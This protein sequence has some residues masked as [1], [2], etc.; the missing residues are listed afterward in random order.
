[1]STNANRLPVELWYYIFRIAVHVPLLFCIE[2]EYFPQERLWEGWESIE[3]IAMETKRAIVQVCRSWREVGVQFLYE[4]IQLREE[5]SERIMDLV[6]VLQ[7]SASAS[8]QGY[9]GWIKRID[10]HST[11]VSSEDVERLASLLECCHN[12]QILSISAHEGS[13]A[14]IQTRLNPIIQSR[15]V[16]SL[17]RLDYFVDNIFKDG[18]LPNVR[19]TSLGIDPLQLSS[20]TPLHPSLAEVTTLTINPSSTGVIRHF[21][22]QWHLPRLRTLAIMHLIDPEIP[23][24]QPF[25]ERH[26]STL[27]H[28]SLQVATSAS[29]RN[30]GRL[31]G[32]LSCLQS[33]TLNDK[34]IPG[35]T[36]TA[37][38][39][40]RNAN[41]TVEY[42]GII[43]FSTSH[44]LDRD[45]ITKGLGDILQH[46]VFPKLKVVRLL[47][48]R[49]HE[50]FTTQAAD[51]WDAAVE[52]CEL[53]LVRLESREGKLISGQ[54]RPAR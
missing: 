54:F 27:I 21:P 32:S 41:P 2:W 24:L 22:S 49:D 36:R 46:G 15:F 7:Q 8:G 14:G 12:L 42:L 43:P 11:L 10:C 28:L 19:L 29:P 3:D 39:D 40:G 25:I 35:L 34:D 37:R 20:D 5:E 51:Y 52:L 48:E 17:N 47:C 44:N 53:H 33:V 23:V 6:N 16:H 38:Q 1:M 45:C 9:G 31:L 13:E 4:A 30:P 26:Q 18:F 50:L